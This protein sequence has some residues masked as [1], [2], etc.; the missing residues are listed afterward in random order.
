MLNDIFLNSLY[1]IALINPISKIC[2]LSVFSDDKENQKELRPIVTKSTLVALLI[3]ALVML[4]GEF[5]FKSFL[6]IE[7]YSLRV[8]GGCVLFWVGF[9]A[10]A[11]GVFFETGTQTRL[12]E[13]SIVPLASPMIAGPATIAAVLALAVEK[14][15]GISFAAAVIAVGINMAFMLLAR[16]IGKVL[17]RFNIMGALIRITGLVVAT[18]GVQMTLSGIG[19]WVAAIA[20]NI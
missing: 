15:F 18:I 9:K 5:L 6:H 4:F 17:V 7:L 16:P 11:K 1:L 12:S 19:E 20:K 2:I 13:I 14:G 10:V 8:A 3:L